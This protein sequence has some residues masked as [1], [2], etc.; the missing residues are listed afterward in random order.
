MLRLEPLQ[1]RHQRQDVEKGM[2]KVLMDERI[3]VQSIHYRLLI[4]L[5]HPG[6]PVP[7]PLAF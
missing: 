6:G 3:R 7:P 2:K 1:Q 5:G 4:S